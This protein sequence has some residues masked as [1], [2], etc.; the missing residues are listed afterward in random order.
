MGAWSPQRETIFNNRTTFLQVWISKKYSNSHNWS[1]TEIFSGQK[2]QLL[3]MWPTRKET[4][5]NSLHNTSCTLGDTENK[6]GEWKSY[7]HSTQVRIKTWHGCCIMQFTTAEHQVEQQLQHCSCFT[8]QQS[9]IR[10]WH[11]H[12][13]SNKH[14][15]HHRLQQAAWWMSSQ[16]KASATSSIHHS[17]ARPTAVSHCGC[18]CDVLHIRSYSVFNEGAVLC[19]HP[20][21]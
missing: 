11:T 10:P 14:R 18:S 6:N 5:N 12:T 21:E 7:G 4:T 8:S 9:Y 2:E 1:I 13:Q 16:T 19:E 17:T 3:L 20:P 15:D